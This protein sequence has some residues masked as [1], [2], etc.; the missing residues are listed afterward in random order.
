MSTMPEKP[1]DTDG[2]R[3][4]HETERTVS[5]R[6][7][8]G[9]G[10]SVRWDYNHHVVPPMTAS[11]TFRLDS[12]QRAA[13][14]FVEFA[15]LEPTAEPHVP[16][17]I[18]D[19]LDEPTRGMLEEN[20]ATAEQG[21]IAVCFAS[22]MGAISSVFGT[23]AKTGEHVVAHHTLY[24]CSYSLL[25]NW[26]PRFGIETTFVD[27]VD[28]GK[29]L[30]VV[31]ENTRVVYFETPVNPDM[32]LI[33]IAQIRR[34]VDGL[35]EKRAEEDRIW[36]AVDN[37]F[38]SPFCQRPL[39]L[40]AHVVVDSLTKSIGGFGTDVGGVVVGPA[41]LRDPLA[42]FRKD[43]G[44]VLSPKSAWDVLVYGLSTLAARMAHYQKSA[45]AIAKYLSEHPKVAKV[46]YPGLES[47]PQYQLARKQM[48]DEHGEFAP[49]S[50][51]YFELKRQPGDA[52]QGQRMI[53]WIAE[54]SYCITLAVSLGQ[55]KT[56]IECPYSMTHSMVPP[57]MKEEEGLDPG[58]IR[59]SVGLEDTGDLIAEL[60][61]ALDNV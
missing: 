32:A 40:G 49:G 11:A 6:M 31:T 56:L 36:I 35:N 1:R 29:L 5:T 17:Y 27:L 55:V 7:I 37:T 24:G 53:D 16:I 60:G 10:S 12:L 61:E 58:G 2:R 48:V 20:L 30:D 22:G 21:E 15:H 26:L 44:A 46:H 9:V 25:T 4:P 8:H 59:L 13:Q 39:A 57:E 43:F 52:S 33:D 54:N 45:L 34:M 23:L 18:Y 3:Y 14:G 51:I 28:P 19:R 41:R 42:L 50:M 38:A 47:F